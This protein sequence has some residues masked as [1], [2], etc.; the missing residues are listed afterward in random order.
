[1][2][3]FSDATISP[4]ETDGTY[5]VRLS[6]SLTGAIAAI[7][8]DFY[9]ERPF[10]RL[11]SGVLGIPLLLASVLAFLFISFDWWDTAVYGALLTSAAVFSSSRFHVYM[12]ADDSKD[13]TAESP[14]APAPAKPPLAP[15]EAA[16]RESLE[17]EAQ[18]Q[19]KAQSHFKW[20]LVALVVGV[21]MCVTV[22]WRILTGGAD[23][24]PGFSFLA[25]VGLALGLLSAVL[26][27][28]CG[29]A[30]NAAARLSRQVHR[31]RELEVAMSLAA[32]EVSEDAK[33]AARSRVLD[34]LLVPWVGDGKGDVLLPT[35]DQ[36]NEQGAG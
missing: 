16:L 5:D 31:L 4:G 13:T 10:L 24:P 7:V 15:L 36:A 14:G 1:M 28:S 9:R 27:N 29:K 19:E 34:L 32:S 25:S 6:L 2:D 26:L 35:I 17:G 33:A 3:I 20:G 11:A 23:V 18:S 8:L 21:T 22:V 30:Q 12:A